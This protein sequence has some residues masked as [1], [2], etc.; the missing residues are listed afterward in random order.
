MNKAG[1]TA[2]L[3]SFAAQRLRLAVALLVALLTLMSGVTFGGWSVTGTGSGYSKALSAQSLTL[4]DA[5]AS[6]SAQLYPGGSGDLVVK[7]TNP[8]PFAV[9]ITAVANGS[10]SIT[11]NKGAAC[12][13]STGVTYTNTTGLSQAVGAG[14]M[15][16][17]SVT[18]KVAMSNASDTSCQGATFTIPITV[19]AT[20]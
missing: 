1:L 5:S 11:S 7:V 14:A 6:T 3:R 4:S 18:G 13:A 8:N 17:F 10:G 2:V 12:D 9:T 15:V 16:T 20:S 19:T